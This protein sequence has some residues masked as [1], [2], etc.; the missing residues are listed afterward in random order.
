MPDFQWEHNMP[1]Q[2]TYTLPRIT[3]GASGAAAITALNAP[4]I[5]AE[6][7]LN[8]LSSRIADM[9]S[10][11]A[12][13]RHYVPVSSDVVAG[14][15]VYYD[16]ATQKFTPALAAL[17]AN[18]GKQGE[19]VEAPS[20]RV[21]GIMLSVDT[22]NLV[23]T[24]LVG[25]Y[26]ESSAVTQYCLGSSATAG[27]YYLSPTTAGKAVS[28]PN[29]HLRQPLISYYGSGK[30]TLHMSV[31]AHDNHFHASAIL[32]GGWTAVAN[33]GLTGITPPAGASFVYLGETDEQFQDLGEL[34]ADTT[35][36]FQDGVL[37]NSSA[38][39]VSDGYLWC[40]LSTAPTSGSVT[41]FNFY[42]FA[43]GSPVIRSVESANDMLSVQTVNGRVR[44]NG[45]S[46]VAGSTAYNALAVAAITG[47]RISYTPVI[48]DIHDGYGVTLTK[49][50]TGEVT[51]STADTIGCLLDAYSVNN[52]GTNITSDGYFTY[53]TFP[54]G[55]NT[56]F[57]MTLP[58]KNT[59]E[60]ATMSATAWA[61]CCGT[62]TTFPVEL[63][64]VPMPTAS[65]SE[66][67]PSTPTSTQLTCSGS[68]SALSFGETTGSIT[69]SGDGMLVARIS[70]NSPS[71][72]IKL[73]RYGFRLA[74]I[75]LTRSGE[76][77]QG[78][79]AETAAVT[80]TLQTS[81]STAKYNVV[82]VN[83]SGK[84]ALCRADTAG[85]GN[86]AVGITLE[87]GSANDSITY[88]MSGI[89]QDTGWTWNPGLPIYVS[90]TGTLTQTPPAAANSAYSQKVGTALTSVAVQVRIETAVMF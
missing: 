58:V 45:A 71:T 16:V 26:Y 54:T 12:I 47:N 1:T 65:T 49:T 13:I 90:P 41:V 75:N 11:S 30:F 18:P 3:A 87:A 52:N 79:I 15:L 31:M 19:S 38:F 4:I 25:G 63:L 14:S 46:F 82:Y 24:M 57:V 9:N 44:L 8:A 39:V 72:N 36:V 83:G 68:G 2:Q 88:I 53:M 64:Y 55:R 7:A 34:S 10:K 62:G 84:L 50:A 86:A 28:D 43:Y 76:S 42:P 89:V 29:G 78:T 33:H 69:F 6:T 48:T 37:Q 27:T 23:G 60:G 35:C 70:C 21:E 85:T 61:E 5:A 56:N 67:L 80:G 66:T 22:S 20:A 73:I 77:Q 17:L 51:I 74:V 32:T 59:R 81:Y 40:K